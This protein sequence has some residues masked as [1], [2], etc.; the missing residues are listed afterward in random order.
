MICK[1]ILTYALCWTVWIDCLEIEKFEKVGKRLLDALFNKHFPTADAS[2]INKAEEAFR[3]AAVEVEIF[4][5]SIHKSLVDILAFKSGT[6]K[7]Q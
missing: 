2:M 7:V 5:K 6:K 4:Y 1:H 3:E